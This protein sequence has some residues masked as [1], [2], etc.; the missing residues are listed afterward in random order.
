MRISDWS[1]DVCSSDL[2]RLDAVLTISNQFVALPSHSP[3]S[4]P[5][6][7]TKGVE[8]YHWSWMS[9]L[10]QA[11]LLLGN[12]RVEPAE[13][14][15]ILAEMVRYFSHPA[16]GVSTFDRM[17]SEWKDVNAQSQAGPKLS[18]PPPAV[19]NP[20]RALQSPGKRR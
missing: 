1:S 7:A 2:V 13:Q 11:Q 19:D 9:L 8:L 20:V 15:Y 6:S 16:V 3:L 18:N 4:L 12:D 10:T 14:R 17:N 5:K